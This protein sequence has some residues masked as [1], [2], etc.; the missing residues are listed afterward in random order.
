MA[1]RTLVLMRHAKSSWDTDDD[2]IDRPLSGRGR[3]DAA[4]AGKLLLERGLA[5]DVALVSPAAR[6]RQTWDAMRGGGLTAG[7]VRTADDVYERDADAIIDAVRDV[8]P[9]ASTVLVIGHS[10]TL[11]EAIDLAAQRAATKDWYAL[12]TKFPTAAM[13][14]IE[15]DGDWAELGTADGTLVAFEVP[16]G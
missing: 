9:A 11:P 5:V 6:A 2:D 13:A 3:R 15:V 7:D 1:T 16:R 4:A 12:D 8:D 14:I 10:P